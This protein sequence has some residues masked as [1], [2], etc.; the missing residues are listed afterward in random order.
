MTHCT[1]ANALRSWN[2]HGPVNLSWL[3]LNA[4]HPI[5]LDDTKYRIDIATC[6][7]G[8]KHWKV[9]NKSGDE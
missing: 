6:E 9:A 4:I 2:L 8:S 1:N 3:A 7:D 5:D